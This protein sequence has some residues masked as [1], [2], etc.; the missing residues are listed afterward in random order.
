MHADDRRI[1]HLHGGVM[2]ASQGVH[3]PSPDASTP[4][5]VYGPK[6]SGRSRYG[7]PLVQNSRI[8][9]QYAI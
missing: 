3:D 2:G 6:L 8:P 5:V 1:D 4:Q 7:A 9:R